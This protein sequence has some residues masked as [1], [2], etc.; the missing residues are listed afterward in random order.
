MSQKFHVSHNGEQLGPYTFEEIVAKV[1]QGVLTI[2]DYLY[3]ENKQDWVGFVEHQ[4][5]LQHI[6][7]SKP[8]APPKKQDTKK[9]LDEES[10]QNV[11]FL[12]AEQKVREISA[13]SENQ[14][15]IMAE[16]FILKGENKFGPFAFTDVIKMLQQK[17][18]FEFDYVWKKGMKAWVRIADMTAFQYENIKKLQETLMPEI[19][20]IFFR[21][22]HRRVKY[23]ATIL[24]HD[25]QSVWKG[26]GVEISQGGAGI[27]M[28][29]AMIV[30][31]QK[32]YLHFKPGDGVPPFNAVCEVVSKKYDENVKEKNSCVLYGVKFTNIS[33]DT[34]GLLK[35]FAEAGEDAA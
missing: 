34:Q 21:R 25:N 14:Q 16:W 15:N 33:E 31:G 22:R 20:E 7:E 28:D 2:M 19:Q 9:D 4:E 23:G 8:K 24:I 18:I 32:L 27:V 17:L 12:Q 30:P 5:L 11:A 10:A 1:N 26:H 35:E 6:K 29:N 13:N 3:D